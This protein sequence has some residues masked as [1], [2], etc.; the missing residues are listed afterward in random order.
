[1]K[2]NSISEID[3]QLI[4]ALQ[5]NIPLT[6]KPFET[7]AKQVGLT[8]TE[9]LAKI[10]QWKE[11]GI[12]RRIGAI[13]THQKLGK[14]A[15]A[16]SVWDL[17]ESCIGDFK[18]IVQDVSE[19]SHS[20]IRKRDPGRNWNYN[21]YAMIHADTQKRCGEIAFDISEKIS[22]KNYLLLRSSTEYKKKSPE[23]F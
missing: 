8:E 17:P 1:M 22:V 10:A 6:P 14:T 13:V 20:Y 18:Q 4:K 15:N 9:V 3:K 12:V 21:A 16:L 19:I 5:G 11:M 23:Y 7:I 2:V